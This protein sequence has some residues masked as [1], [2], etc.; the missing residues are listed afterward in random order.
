MILPRVPGRL[1]R[2]K[3][4]QSWMRVAD[5]IAEFAPAPF[6]HIMDGSFP[7]GFVSPSGTTP[8]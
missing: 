3:E 4:K 7:A 6:W 8:G 5:A 2:R 1:L